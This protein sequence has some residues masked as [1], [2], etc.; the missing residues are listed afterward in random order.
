ME[1]QNWKENSWEKLDFFKMRQFEKKIRQ[2][3]KWQTF[4]ATTTVKIIYRK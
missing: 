1:Y 2:T 4:K 3:L